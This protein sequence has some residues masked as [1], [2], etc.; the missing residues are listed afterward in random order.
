M[1]NTGITDPEILEYRYPVKL[2]QFAL[3]NNS[4]GD[5]KYSG[6]DGVI[7]ELEFSESVTLSL[8]TQHRKEQ[9]YGLCGGQPGQAGEQR[10]L[11]KGEEP[12]SLDSTVTVDLQAGDRI[13]ILTPGGGAWGNPP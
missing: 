11:R 4:G 8:L 3:R 6:G 12:K 13:R 7:R 1:T 2:R 9:P 5:G 10:L